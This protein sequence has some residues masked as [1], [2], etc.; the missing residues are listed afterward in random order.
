[1]QSTEADLAA[2]FQTSV[3]S[4]RE[5]IACE[6]TQLEP[7]MQ[8]NPSPPR[9]LVVDDEPRIR[10]AIR[11]C[12]E[13]EG[14][15]VIEAAD[16]VEALDHII[17]DAPDVMILDLAMPNLDG[18]R[19]LGELNGVH[20]QLKPRVIVLTAWASF[21]AAARS[22]GLGASLFLSKPAL[23]EAIRAA[24]HHVLNE[25]SDAGYGIPIDW[26][27]LLQDASE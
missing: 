11:A 15:Q 16:G 27:E 3:F 22:M 19:T 12:L 17:T 26:T 7:E 10:L 23:P 24:V 14:Y 1:M 13:D 2:V 8:P 6:E 18:L 4:N 9:V 25:P 21:P 5:M 20:G